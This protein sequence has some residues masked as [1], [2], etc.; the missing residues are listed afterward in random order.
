MFGVLE[1]WVFFPG[2]WCLGGIWRYLE[3]LS[4]QSTLGEKPF[5][6]RT[7]QIEWKRMTRSFD[8]N[9]NIFLGTNR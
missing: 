8:T 9:D 1:V 4:E 5:P 7:I 2:V 6:F 3:V